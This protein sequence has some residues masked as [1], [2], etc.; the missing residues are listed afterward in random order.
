MAEQERLRPSGP[1]RLV[2][3]RWQRNVCSR[4]SSRRLWISGGG[5]WRGVTLSGHAGIGA[6]RGGCC[7]VRTRRRVSW[8]AVRTGPGTRSQKVSKRSE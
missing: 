3:G 7:G 1:W 8:P 6:R 4:F 2:N 5:R